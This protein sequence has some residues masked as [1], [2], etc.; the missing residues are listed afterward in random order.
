MHFVFYTFGVPSSK[1]IE[2]SP[3]SKIKMSIHFIFDAELNECG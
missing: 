1:E 2:E 3:P